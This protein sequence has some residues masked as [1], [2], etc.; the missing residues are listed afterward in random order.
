MKWVVELSRGFW[1]VARSSDSR[2]R[3]SFLSPNRE[4]AQASADALNMIESENYISVAWSK[5]S[6]LL[7]V[8]RFS[9]GWQV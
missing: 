2:V 3:A 7:Y 8:P 1:Y 4:T 6:Q 5:G 9:E